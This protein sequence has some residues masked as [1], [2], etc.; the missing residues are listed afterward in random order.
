MYIEEICEDPTSGNRT[1]NPMGLNNG[2][3]TVGSTVSFTCN[4]GYHLNGADSAICQDDGSW[5]V[6][7]P[8][9]ADSTFTIL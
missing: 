4:S 5:S 6:E 2:Q 7:L 1:F 3:Y 8:T 9:C